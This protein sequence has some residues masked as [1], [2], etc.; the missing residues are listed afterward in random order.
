MALKTGGR[1]DEESE[2]GKVKNNK[3]KETKGK[4]PVFVLQY[5]RADKEPWIPDHQGLGPERERLQE[6]ETE[7]E[8]R[9]RA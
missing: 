8:R 5:K 3:R 9:T 7:R 4:Q 2:M 1:I 6:K